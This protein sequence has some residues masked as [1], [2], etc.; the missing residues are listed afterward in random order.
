MYKLKRSIYYCVS[1]FNCDGYS[2]QIVC[3]F[4]QE[5]LLD[6]HRRIGF[7]NQQYF[8]SFPFLRMED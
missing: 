4:A 1:L 7:Q 5:Q 6:Q 3:S 8:L 2:T